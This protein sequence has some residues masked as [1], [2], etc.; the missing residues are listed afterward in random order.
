VTLSRTRT[1]RPSRPSMASRSVRPIRTSR[2]FPRS[3]GGTRWPN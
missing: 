1:W 2:D 3:P